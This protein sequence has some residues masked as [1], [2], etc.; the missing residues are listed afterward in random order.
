MKTLSVDGK[1][2]SVE[3][4]TMLY[5]A[6]VLA[7]ASIPTL[8][9]HE[10]LP[11]EGACRVCMVEL[12]R[13]GTVRLVASCMFP[14]NEE[15]LEVRTD[16]E[17]VRAARNFVIRLLLRRNGDSAAIRRL[18]A[19]ENVLPDERLPALEKELCIRCGR[20]IRACSANGTDA[21][22]FALRGWDRK[23][24]PPFGEAAA[25]CVGCLACAEVCPTGHIS[26]EEKDGHRRIWGRNFALVC[27][28]HCGEP[29]ATEEQLAFLRAGHPSDALSPEEE[30]F[31]PRCR[32][33]RAGQSFTLEE[34]KDR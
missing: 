6:A 31:C 24:T 7:G 22:G 11:H 21:L 15:G 2:V 34:V 23:T 19:E 33:I 29:F 14:V 26:W 10:G 28:E 17:R 8:C 13:R 25:T 18:A 16:T 5:D 27:C 3:S 9:R 1:T 4:G 30:R 12:H 20:C 32:R